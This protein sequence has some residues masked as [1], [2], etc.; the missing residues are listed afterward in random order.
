LKP[1]DRSERNH[2]LLQKSGETKAKYDDM[3]NSKSK[4][5]QN[6]M[7]SIPVDTSSSSGSGIP[8]DTSSSSG[9]GFDIEP[10]DSGDEVEVEPTGTARKLNSIKTLI[11]QQDPLMD[12][13]II[14]NLNYKEATDHLYNVRT[15]DEWV[16]LNFED[17]TQK[18]M[19]NG[20]AYNAQ[21]L[22]IW[23]IQHGKDVVKNLKQKQQKQASSDDVW[24]KFE[25]SGYKRLNPTVWHDYCNENG[26]DNQIPVVFVDKDNKAAIKILDVG[27]TTGVCRGW[28]RL[29]NCQ[30]YDKFYGMPELEKCERP[31]KRQRQ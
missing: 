6:K 18:Y 28:E 7:S 30:G 20:N 21:E 15:D 22:V 23:C 5:N 25:R 19:L 3:T 2:F 13:D 11:A 9:S 4:Q 24:A 26:I 10:I 27:V 29:K 14:A 16:T 12:G 31:P 17:Q 1:L 8:V